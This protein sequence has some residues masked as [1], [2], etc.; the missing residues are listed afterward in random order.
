MTGLAA[1]VSLP[2]DVQPSHRG[3][4]SLRW[5]SGGRFADPSSEA[6]RCPVARTALQVDLSRRLDAP[7]RVVTHEDSVAVLSVSDDLEAITRLGLDVDRRVQVIHT[8]LGAR[9]RHRHLVDG[10]GRASSRM[11]DSR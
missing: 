11:R 4:C 8:A 6:V 7:A 9:D 2:G 1:T 10:T 5:R 3:R